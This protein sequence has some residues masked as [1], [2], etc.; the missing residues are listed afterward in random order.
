[1]GRIDYTKPGGISRPMTNSQK[2]T[3]T[4]RQTLRIF[5]Y[6]FKTKAQYLFASK[7]FKV[8]A[9]QVSIKSSREI[10]KGLCIAK[11]VWKL[12]LALPF[13]G[14]YARFLRGDL[15]DQFETEGYVLT[16]R[17]KGVGRW[18][19]MVRHALRNS[20][21]GLL[22][23]VG[24]NFGAMVGGTVVIEQVFALPGIGQLMLH[25]INA[26]DIVVVQA[27]VLFLA[28]AL[29]ALPLLTGDR[30]PISHLPTVSDPTKAADN[31]QL[32]ETM[33]LV[34]GALLW[35]LAGFLTL[36]VRWLHRHGGLAMLERWPR[37]VL[38]L[39]LGLHLLS[40]CFH[41]SVQDTQ[42]GFKM[43]R[44]DVGRELF[45]NIRE[46]GYLFDLE[47]LALA[48]HFGYEVVEVPVNWSEIPGGSMNILR[49]SPKMLMGLF[50][51]RQRLAQ[52]TDRHA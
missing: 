1:M 26:R 8:G 51:L 3:K 46:T 18:G 50:R 29:L 9:E 28:G 27:I 43:F 48:N 19:I 38:A 35:L 37:K 7:G 30:S 21:F 10:R 34:E 12:A 15:L 49:D 5:R 45:E 41:I 6:I 16:A 42:C 17:A 14:L 32:M 22:T 20:F 33:L 11:V 44:R 47:L 23:L 25:A 40:A 2:S 52:N 36:R 24:L 39:L 13:L 31:A 4:F